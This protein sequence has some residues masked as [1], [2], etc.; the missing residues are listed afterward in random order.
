M[1]NSIKYCCRTVQSRCG[2]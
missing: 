2:I 1:V